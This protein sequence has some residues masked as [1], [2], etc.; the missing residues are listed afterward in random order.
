MSKRTAQT[1]F[2]TVITHL[3]RQNAKALDRRHSCSYRGENG[4]KGA[5]GCLISDG[6]YHQSMEG[7]LYKNIAKRYPS[8]FWMKEF[9]QL[10][11]RLQST[12]DLYDVS[13]WEHQFALIAL[14]F[15]LEFTE[16]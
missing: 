16:K 11:A 9:D 1:V 7:S 8:C 4:T 5:I 15:G 2:N 13:L 14:G 3:R 10:L 12:H 6:D